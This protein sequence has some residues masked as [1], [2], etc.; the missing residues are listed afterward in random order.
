MASRRGAE[1]HGLDASG[2]LL[3]IASARTPDGDFRHGDMHDLPWDDETFDAVT[4]FWG[5]WGANDQAV[6]EAG[7]VL[8]PGGTLALTFF[9]MDQP[10]PF[11]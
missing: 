5:I 8:K 4:S 2:R 1:V 3:A 7:R 11:D 9:P 10:S 6:G